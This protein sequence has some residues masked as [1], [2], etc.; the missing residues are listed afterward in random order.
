MVGFINS[1]PHGI[2][3]ALLHKSITFKL[4]FKI[5][6]M[7]ES[8]IPRSGFFEV[9]DTWDGGLVAPEKRLFCLSVS[10][11]SDPCLLVKL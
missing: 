4:H 7:G 9:L 8:R 11:G 2:A 10:M 1:L 6:L 5:G 3:S